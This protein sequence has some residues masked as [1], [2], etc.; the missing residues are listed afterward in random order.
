VIVDDEAVRDVRVYDV[1]REL[2]RPGIRRF[3]ML[4]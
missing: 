3:G 4:T 1:T 2:R